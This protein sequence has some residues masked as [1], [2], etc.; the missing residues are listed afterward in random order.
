MDGSTVELNGSGGTRG[1][2]SGVAGGEIREGLY[3]ARE[4]AAGGVERG[5]VIEAG[6]VRCG[7][8]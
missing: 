5:E 8:C 6:E 4:V 3:S 2:S 7:V 1:E